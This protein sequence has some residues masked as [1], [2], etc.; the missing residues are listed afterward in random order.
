MVTQ[1]LDTLMGVEVGVEKAGD[2]EFTGTLW[3]GWKNIGE[4]GVDR[5][6]QV[7]LALLSYFAWVGVD[8]A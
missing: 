7:G 3:R 5:V 2:L 4:H 1:F 8:G 6:V